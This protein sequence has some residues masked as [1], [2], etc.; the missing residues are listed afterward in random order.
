MFP[1]R[2]LG[3]EARLRGIVSWLHSGYKVR[4]PLSPWTRWT[5]RQE[6]VKWIR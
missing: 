3:H 5:R 2:L 4:F 6:E 1:P